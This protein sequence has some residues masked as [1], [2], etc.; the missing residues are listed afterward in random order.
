MC[1]ALIVIAPVCRAACYW[2]VGGHS[3]QKQLTFCQMDALAWGGLLAMA[4]RHPHLRP[5]AINWA[6]YSLILGA[7][8]FGLAG[9][10]FQLLSQIRSHYHFQLHD[11]FSLIDSLTGFLFASLLALLMPGETRLPRG[12]LT[13]VGCEALG[14]TAIRCTFCMLPDLLASSASGHAMA[15]V[16]PSWVADHCTNNPIRPQLR[17]M[18]R[19]SVDNV[20]S[21]GEPFPSVKEPICVPAS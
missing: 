13:C 17:R 20:E 10:F 4:M 2:Y 11:P 5:R 12:S 14:N 21:L 9:A 19:G 7:I 15:P 16:A 18:L 6:R 1:L 8:L 3:L